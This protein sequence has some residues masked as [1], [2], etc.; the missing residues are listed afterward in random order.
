VIR[1]RIDST[2]EMKQVVRRLERA[3]GGRLGRKASRNLVQA[4]RPV[5]RAI[6]TAVRAVEV[7]SSRGGTA[8]PDT[9]TNLRGRIAAAV[10]GAAISN[11]VAL[12]IEGWQL[13]VNG[14]R[15]AQYL[16]TEDLPRWR[17]PVFG[18]RSA[19]WQTN[20]GQPYFYVTIRGSEPRF[21]D[22]VEAAV[23]D[24]AEEI[25]Q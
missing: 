10:N 25:C 9:S 1:I 3:S 24:I 18:R 11:G 23:D 22:A 8:R 6:Q 14:S 12:F 13:G 2:R 16:D 17:Y 15:L 20:V 21:R 5:R 19:P 7:G 4:S